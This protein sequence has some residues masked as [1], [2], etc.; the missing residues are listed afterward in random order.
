MTQALNETGYNYNDYV[1]FRTGSNNEILAIQ[2][3]AKQITDVNNAI[4][5]KVNKAI[6]KFDSQKIYIH[7]G[8]ISGINFLSGRGPKVPIKLI[9]KG[10]SNSKI[11]SKLEEAGI[12]QTLHKI[13]I[14]I[15]VDI[16]GFLAGFTTNVETTSECVLSESLIVGS[17]PSSYTK[18]ELKNPQAIDNK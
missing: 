5:N 11:I 13:R 9:S 18:I 14:L 3:N 15:T 17:I 2:T 8:T 4:T 16:A 6:S 12:N 1:T 7:L 10:I